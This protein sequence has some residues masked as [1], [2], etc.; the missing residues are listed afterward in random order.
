M[1]G[2]IRFF[3]AAVFYAG[4]VAS[5]VKLAAQENWYGSYAGSVG[6]DPVIFH[7]HKMGHT[8]AGYFY[9]QSVGQPSYLYGDDT[10]A[11]A[12]KVRLFAFVPGDESGSQTFTLTLNSNGFSGEWKKDDKSK[13]IA[14]NATSITNAALHFDMI[15]KR[16]SVKLRPRLKESPEGSYEAGT[17]WPKE[18]SMAANGIKS[19]VRQSFGQKNSVQDIGKTLESEKSKYIKEYLA[20]YKDVADSE[21]VEY[22]FTYN[23]EQSRWLIIA[24]HSPQLL[25]LADWNYSY[26][27]G[28][29]GMST[30]SFATFNLISGKKLGL[31]DVLLPAGINKLDGLVDT[32]FRKA[33]G[34]KKGDDL[35]DAG[36]FENK[37]KHNNNFYVTSKGIGFNYSAYEI[38]SYALGDIDV[39]VPFSA[40]A[41]WLQPSFRKLVH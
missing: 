33:H 3:L 25:V 1:Y 34:L 14:V 27:G 16:G 15:Y 32:Y 21:M 41:T 35:T 17:I 22:P 23:E 37:I 5:P 28:A 18:N 24:F 11:G 39:F 10:T 36:L 20:G 13:P 40:M 30:T 9:Y 38:A 8:Y 26:S 6:T 29:H 31:K 2:M 7:L 19:F 12:S 4:L